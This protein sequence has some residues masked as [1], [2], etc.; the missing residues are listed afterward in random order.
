MQVGAKARYEANDVSRKRRKKVV[1]ECYARSPPN[2][3]M[4]SRKIGEK[5]GRLKLAN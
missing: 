3:F 2:V 5:K 1:L 4:E